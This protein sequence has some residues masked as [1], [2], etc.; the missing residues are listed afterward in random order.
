MNY[1]IVI[2]WAIKNYTVVVIWKMGIVKLVV[3]TMAVDMVI[4][5]TSDGRISSLFTLTIVS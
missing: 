2:G 1:T 4:L 5:P 3:V